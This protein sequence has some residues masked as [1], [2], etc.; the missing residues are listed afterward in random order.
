MT[1]KLSNIYKIL[2]SIQQ[3]LKVP[4]DLKNIF[5]NF[6][7]RN[8]E[9]ILQAY[10]D[11][12]SKENYPTDIILTHEFQVSAIGDR[13]FA[14]CTSIL[15][16]ADG[17]KKEATGFAGIDAIKKGMD[18][19]QIAGAAISYAKKYALCNLFAIDDS[20]DDPDSNEKPEE[21]PSN[22]KKLGKALD[23]A[24]GEV[25]R[26][27]H[28]K[29]FVRIKAIFELCENITD[30]GVVWAEEKKSI[31]S[32]QKYADDLYQ[33]LVEAKDAI[34]LRLFGNE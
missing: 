27:E 23:G 13:I 31:A 33:R 21:E 1:E 6:M 11:E 18:Q 25:Q 28:E 16:L 12:V 4:K 30:L 5:G 7:Y 32:M 34:K 9:G 19:A 26:A 24:M 22:I 3:N 2:N 15:E 14:I 8:A 17:S 10:K 20:K 29:E